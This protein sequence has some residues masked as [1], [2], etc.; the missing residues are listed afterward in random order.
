M[1]IPSAMSLQGQSLLKYW[2]S[3]QVSVDYH[4]PQEE[5]H[6]Q[7]LAITSATKIGIIYDKT[8]MVNITPL[9]MTQIHKNTYTT[10]VILWRIIFSQTTPIKLWRSTFSADLRKQCRKLAKACLTTKYF[11]FLGKS[12]LNSA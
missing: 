10:L 7:K 4:L 11:L 12:G 5:Q 1:A 2:D 9:Y 3:I 8:T 6:Q